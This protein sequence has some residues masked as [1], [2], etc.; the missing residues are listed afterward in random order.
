VADFIPYIIRVSY[1]YSKKGGALSILDYVNEGI[2]GAYDAFDKCN[3]KG[4][5]LIR[6][7]RNYICRYIRN[8]SQKRDALTVAEFF[9]DEYPAN[10]EEYMREREI[11]DQLDRSRENLLLANILES[12]MGH[13]ASII[14]D[15]YLER[16][17][18]MNSIAEKYGISRERVR[19]IIN[20]FSRLHRVKHLWSILSK[21][22]NLPVHET[23]YFLN[24]YNHY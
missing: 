24:K 17:A 6:T 4:E 2:V 21:D 13:R 9:I 23:R 18:D 20:N 14:L 5:V 16:E 15:Y 8:M 1:V 12:H 22:F 10:D 11:I 19:Q 7:I 3:D